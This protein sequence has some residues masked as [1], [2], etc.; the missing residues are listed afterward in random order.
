MPALGVIV[1]GGDRK[2]RMRVIVPSS[3]DQV[4]GIGGPGAN[5]HAV[6]SSKPQGALSIHSPRSHQPMTHA[7]PTSR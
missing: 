2:D 4:K 5:H 3:D 1:T 7:H 6:S